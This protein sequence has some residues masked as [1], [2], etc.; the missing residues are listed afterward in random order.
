MTEMIKTRIKQKP[1]NSK[2]I[3][4]SVIVMVYFALLITYP[5][6][7]SAGIQNGINCCLDILIP[8]MFPFMVGAAAVTLSGID[9]KFKFLFGRATK[10]LFYL[11]PCVVP[12]VIISLFG[13]YPVGAYCVKSLY[14]SGSINAEQMNRMMCYCVNFGPAFIIS[15]LGQ[16]LLND[17]KLGVILFLI[18][19]FS[20]VLMGIFLGVTARISKTDFYEK[21]I[22]SQKKD[23]YFSKILISA[24]DSASKSLLGVCSLVTLFFGIIS[25]INDLG[26]INYISN[27]FLKINISSHISG[28]LILSFIEM[29]QSCILGAKNISTP[30]FIYSWIIGFGGICAHTQIIAQLG[31]CPFKYGKFLIMRT[32]NG[33]LTAFATAL[34]IKNPEKTLQTFAPLTINQT[35]EISKASPT[36]IGSVI[37]LVFCI[38]FTFSV[39]FKTKAIFIDKHNKKA[40]AKTEQTPDF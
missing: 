3:I 12:A 24:C 33:I 6:S 36:H 40:S 9:D 4:L 10:F 26:I 19:V 23:L 25:F 5:K 2:H 22:H 30:Y 18:Q 27:I 35:A 11:P 39:D 14:K 32:I 37:L 13:G 16:M 1:K 17:Y 7:V 34:I 28:T 29:T 8:S 31:S 38:F 20:S 15:A 21:K